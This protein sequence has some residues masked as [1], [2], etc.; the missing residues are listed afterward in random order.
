MSSTINASTASGGG[1]IT[2]A[3]AS[4]IL[5]LQ[6]AGVT[7]L[8]ID[9]SQN[10]GIG[11]S[12]P[13]ASKLDVLSATGTQNTTADSP[14]LVNITGPSGPTSVQPL[15]V[16][17]INDVLAANIGPAITFQARYLTS[18]TAAANIAYIAALRENATSGNVQGAITFNPRNAAGNFP[19]AMRIDSSGNVGIGTSSPAFKLDVS[20]ASGNAYISVARN[21]LASGQV[22]LQINGGTSG[23][24]WY[25]YN[26]ASSNDLSFFGNGSERMRIDSSGNL[27][28]GTTSTAPRDF[29]SGTASKIPGPGNPVEFAIPDSNCMFLNY[30]GSASGSATL[31]T[32][33]Q[34]GINRGTI[35]TN[36]STTSYNTT[37]DYRLKDNISPMVGALDKVVQLKPVTY[38][39]KQ[40][41]SNG[42]GFIAHEL[43]AVVP[44]CV[45]GEKDAVDKDGKPQYQ[46]IDTSFL[47]ATLTA[48]IQEQQTL[49]EA[50]TA[51]LTALEAK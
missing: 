48:A 51:R 10:V 32:F 44:D 23:T 29:T 42:Q 13:R 41:G 6:T 47:V 16:L 24:I 8:T 7:G 33:R 2:S 3:D 5:A 27:L 1:I 50:L 34:Q 38:T 25:L 40:N 15:F 45:V 11:T 21:A 19:E 18:S 43:Q 20:A 31:V 36:G 26:A 49:I 14:G 12:S 22:G 4:G 28:V 37:S 17:G 9:A 30:T 39:W 35:A 46:G